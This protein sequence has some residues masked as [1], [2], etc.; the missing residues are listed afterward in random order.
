MK[1]RQK[2]I[3]PLKK[4]WLIKQTYLLLYIDIN[5]SKNHLARPGIYKAS[6]HSFGKLSKNAL[7]TNRIKSYSSKKKSV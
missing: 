3:L 1:I 5:I 2:L 7:C 6:L 4:L